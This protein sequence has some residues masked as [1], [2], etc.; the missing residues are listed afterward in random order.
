MVT[1]CQLRITSTSMLGEEFT[2]QNQSSK[3]RIACDAQLLFV[4]HLQS[5][6]CYVDFSLCNL[7]AIIMSL[8]LRCTCGLIPLGQLPTGPALVRSG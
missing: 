3:F 6:C 2:K 4:Q 5:Y 1:T 8:A 7:I